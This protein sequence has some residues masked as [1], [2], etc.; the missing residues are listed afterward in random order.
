MCWSQLRCLL[1]L[2]FFSIFI[3][4]TREWDDGDEAVSKAFR[5]SEQHKVYLL[6]IWCKILA[7]KWACSEAKRGRKNTLSPFSRSPFHATPHYLNVWNRLSEE[8][9]PGSLPIGVGAG[10][11]YFLIICIH[12]LTGM[13]RWIGSHIHDWTDY[14]GVT[15]S[16]EFNAS[17]HFRIFRGKTVLHIYG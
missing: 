2:V 5:K 16:I 6:G 8:E 9:E 17:T 4:L 15:F 1:Y 12:I 3:K 10:V 14:N 11:G 13:C 7:Y